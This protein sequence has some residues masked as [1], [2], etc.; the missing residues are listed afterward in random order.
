MHLSKEHT[1]LVYDVKIKLKNCSFSL[2]FSGTKHPLPVSSPPGKK[3]SLY[4]TE[5]GREA[6]DQLYRLWEGE[7]RIVSTSTPSPVFLLPLDSQTQ[8]VSDLLNM[9]IGVASSTFPLNQV[10]FII[11]IYKSLK[12]NKTQLICCFSA[13]SD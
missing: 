3:E 11:F 6:F 10:L 12:C 5:G 13:L 9:L 2:L 7:M 4:L 8:L 1:Y